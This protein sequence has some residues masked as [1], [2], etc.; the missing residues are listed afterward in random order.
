MKVTV[1]L[2]AGLVEAGWSAA[3]CGVDLSTARR[4]AVAAVSATAGAEPVKARGVTLRDTLR[5]AKGEELDELEE[6]ICA[7]ERSTSRNGEV[8]AV[9]AKVLEIAGNNGQRNNTLEV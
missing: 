9:K 4:D 3:R 5:A 8:E 1:E 7:A 2:I 6:A